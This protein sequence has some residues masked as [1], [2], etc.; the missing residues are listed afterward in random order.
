MREAGDRGVP[1][2]GGGGGEFRNNL[3]HKA[4][5]AMAGYSKGLARMMTST[6][7]SRPSLF[8]SETGQGEQE[9]IRKRSLAAGGDS[10]GQQG[11]KEGKTLG[12]QASKG[13]ERTSTSDSTTRDADENTRDI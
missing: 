13:W 7:T 2:D 8:G 5:A 11:R 12:R 10:S 3:A 1:V 4:G 9:G 6:S